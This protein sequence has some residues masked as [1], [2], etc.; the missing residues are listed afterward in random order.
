MTIGALYGRNVV[1]I[2]RHATAQD[3][4]VLMRAP[5]VDREG[6]LRGL[7][8]VDDPVPLLAREPA[9]IAVMIR[10][11]QLAEA[12]RTDDSFRDEFATWGDTYQAR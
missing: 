1:T 10:R 5:I 6:H 2:D 9:R 4:A 7:V 12:R 8:S 11:E 3:A